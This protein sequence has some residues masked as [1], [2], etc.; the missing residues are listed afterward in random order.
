VRNVHKRPETVRAEFRVQ[1]RE[2]ELWD[3][4]AES[5]RAV[6]AYKATSSGTR[7][8]L[9][10]EP[11]NSVFVV[12]RRRGTAPGRPA[13]LEARDAQALGRPL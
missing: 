2:P 7:L 9:R 5:I 3:A 8:E 1:G 12:F 4:A 6:G 11:Q 13:P 10:L